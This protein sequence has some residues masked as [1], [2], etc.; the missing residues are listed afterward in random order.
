MPA[1]HERNKNS[2]HRSGVGLTRSA[3][4]GRGWHRRWLRRDLAKAEVASLFRRPQFPDAAPH[5]SRHVTRG[6]VDAFHALQ[7]ALTLLL[8]AA[9]YLCLP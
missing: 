9:V 5:R 2:H 6:F 3:R 4:A 8:N 7:V 1:A